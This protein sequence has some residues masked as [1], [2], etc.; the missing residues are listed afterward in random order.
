[1]H[2]ISWFHCLNDT[3]VLPG[4][5][6]PLKVFILG[7]PKHNPNAKVLIWHPTSGFAR[8]GLKGWG[9]GWGTHPQSGHTGTG[10][11]D[12]C[13]RETHLPPLGKV[14]S[15]SS[16]LGCHSLM[17]LPKVLVTDC[18]GMHAAREVQSPVGDPPPVDTAL[19][20]QGHQALS[21]GEAE[22]THPGEGY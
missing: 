9:G 7:V 5:A 20:L 10:A 22:C 11:G 8:A 16:P 18:W 14:T 12:G 17:V 2:W 3:L 4:V 13:L 19:G 6:L 15:W 1:M 21:G